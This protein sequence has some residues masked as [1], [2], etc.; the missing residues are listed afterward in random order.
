[1][2][3][4]I[5]H[6]YS[7]RSDSSCLQFLC[8]TRLQNQ[9]PRSAGPARGICTQR[10]SGR[11]CWWVSVEGQVISSVVGDISL[12]PLFSIG[13]VIMWGLPQNSSPKICNLNKYWEVEYTLSFQM[14]WLW[15]NLKAMYLMHVRN[16]GYVDVVRFLLWFKNSSPWN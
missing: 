13:L 15:G 7:K 16:S 9:I 11:M 12:C 1:M 8:I 10:L 14:I 6:I 2:K 3:T 4:P 5:Q